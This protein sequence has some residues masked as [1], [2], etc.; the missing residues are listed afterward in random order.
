VLEYWSIG[1]LEYWS[2]GVLE[3][4]SIGVVEYWG[5]EAEF[6]IT[7]SLHRSITPFVS[8]N[9]FVFMF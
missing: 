8:F 6:F 3:Y 7:P 2:I 9:P 1:V 5:Q 4:W